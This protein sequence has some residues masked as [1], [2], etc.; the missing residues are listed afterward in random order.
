MPFIGNAGQFSNLYEKNYETTTLQ[1]IEGDA[2]YQSYNPENSNYKLITNLQEITD[3]GN[4][5]SNTVQ[6]TNVTT[7]FV[8]TSNV[9][10][11]NT[12]PIHTLDIGS[13]FS[14]N[15]GAVTRVSL[16]GTLYA[17][18]S[19]GQTASFTDSVTSRDVIVDRVYPKT[20]GYVNLTSNIGLL[21]TSPIHTLQIGSN[22][23]V[24]EYASNTIHTVG[25]VYAN[26]YKGNEIELTGII[27]ASDFVLTGG[28]QAT[29]TPDLQAVS[30]A[31]STFS[32]DR[33]LT[34]SNVTTALHATTIR[35]ITTYSNL[36]AGNVTAVTTRSNLIAGNVSAV[37]TYSNLIAG[38]VSTVTTRSNLI[39]DNVTAVTT[40]SNL[41]ANNVT[42]LTT[43]SNLIAD[44]VTAVT[45]RSNLIADNVSA[46]TTRSNLIA[47]NIITSGNLTVGSNK[48]FV[49]A[50]A[51][52]VGINKATP[53]TELDVE[54]DIGCSGNI[55]VQGNFTVN[56]AFTSTESTSLQVSDPFIEIGSGNN[57]STLDLGFLLTRETANV[58]IFFDESADEVVVGYTNDNV[59][60]SSI[61]TIATPIGFRV[62]GDM[63]SDKIMS[64][65]YGEIKGS[66]VA[67]VSLLTGDTSGDH[68]GEIKGSNAASVSLLTG[69]TSGDHYGEIKGS[70]AA[71]VSLLTGD[72][73]GDHYGE[74]KGSNAA[75]VSILSGLT[76][77]YGNILGSNVATVSNLVATN[78]IYGNILGS[79]T[80]T[81]SDIKAS[82]VIISTAMYG[83]IS[84][85]NTASVSTLTGT[86][87]GTHYGDISGSNAASVSTLSSSSGV[88]G[89]I[90]GSNAASVSSLF[91]T[92][93][94]GEIKGSNA[95]SVSS[96]FCTDLHGE[97]KGS[98]AASVSTL[99]C[100]DLY[101]EI[102]GSNAASVSTLLCTDLYGEIK[103]SNAASV[104]TLL[105]TDL[106]G[107]I[108]GSN[109]ASVSDINASN[110][111][112]STAMYGNISGSNTATVSD[113][114]A[115][116]VII[117]TAM[118][119][120]ISGSNTASVSTLTGTTVGT[121][122]GGIS[123][124]NTASFD[125][126][127]FGSATKQH[128]NLYD[129]SYG[130]GIQNSTQYYRTGGG[131]AWFKGGVHAYNA[132]D[133][134]TGGAL[135]MKLDSAYNLTVT[136]DVTA[137]SDE[138]VKT[139]I[140]HIDNALDKVCSIN[141]YTYQRT[142]TND[143]K[144]H[145]GVLAQEVM[146]V[147]PEVVHGSEDTTYSV[148]YGNMVGLLIEAIKELKLEIDELKKL[149]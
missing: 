64:N 107:E 45:T 119:G 133:P 63:T 35:S 118:Y 105:C 23:Y 117:S 13:K 37:T 91:C 129:T 116:N 123:G 147:L 100:T 29:P 89:E 70:N 121:H 7:G 42:A 81:V 6:F 34:L 101:G 5:T 18:E 106:Y 112:I 11:A 146:K 46:V 99:L 122:Y 47:S 75:S 92:D 108:K 62:Y 84:G 8:T 135:A 3:I 12:N 2:V 4:V 66:N 60:S 109:V 85:S 130:I 53:L 95:A 51:G 86:T 97:I 57:T 131:F 43:R 136:S 38:N 77:I 73:S 40:R 96:L 125:T 114:T 90:K 67:S 137:Y 33:T 128:V 22:V 9:G 50:S 78:A 31:G 17:S 69:V 55:I 103:G 21:N 1:I 141:G 138:R 124:S 52:K 98:N 27:R 142:D 19:S 120:K 87:V 39:A 80:A 56:G 145:T 148:A 83:K 15:V 79:N 115:S 49:D 59:N 110:V 71:S 65:L 61:T 76:G 10:I 113:I 134:G 20:S 149:K 72:T 16:N 36:I 104:S 140:K 102:K 94:Y 93:L 126:I 14:V 82:N 44:N 68:Y 41:I 30:E 143:D 25:N 24:D 48:L 74:I 28:S 111:I 26:R 32:S 88:H 54:G 144:R 58:A 132:N 139:D 127:S